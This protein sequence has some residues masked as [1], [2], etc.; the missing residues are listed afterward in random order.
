MKKAA[1]AKTAVEGVAVAAIICAAGASS[2]MAGPDGGLKKEYRP[3]YGGAAPKGNQKLASLTVLGAAVRAFA[4]LPE[5][6]TIVIAVP[7]DPATGEAAAR[8]AI[9]PALLSGK[10]GPPVHF[11]AGGRTRR[12]S[13]FNALSVLPEKFL[14]RLDARSYVL[15]HDGARPWVRPSFIRGIIAEVKKHPAVVPVL[16]LTETPKETTL[17][18]DGSG[19]IYVKRHLRRACVGISQT[20]QAFAFPEILDL[21]EM[22]AEHER[23]TGIEFTDDAEIWGT[24]HGS[25]AVVPGDPGNRKVTFPGDLA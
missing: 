9:P 20:P 15:I 12:L 22:A 21:H 16:P 8:K 10:I 6:Q 19:P 5:I 25:V 2:R 3:L 24:F 17:A 7:D 1:V 11:V 13:V 14:G 4:A 23:V 18:L